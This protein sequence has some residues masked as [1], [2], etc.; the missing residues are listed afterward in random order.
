VYRRTDAGSWVQT[1]QLTPW[2][3][4][5]E[6]YDPGVAMKGGIAVVGPSRY[7]YERVGDQW[8]RKTL[9]SNGQPS[10]YLQGTDLEISGT[11]MLST[12]DSWNWSGV[13]WDRAADGQWSESA[14]LRGEFAW[15]GD[16]AISA[17]LDLSGN[18]A[19]IGNPYT[20]SPEEAPLVP[21]ARTFRYANGGW[22]PDGDLQNDADEG[23][24]AWHVAM[25][26][27]HAFVAGDAWRGAH[28]YLRN[29]PAQWS[30]IDR[31]DTVDSY[32]NEHE[33]LEHGER[34][35]LQRAFSRERDAYVIHV[36]KPDASGGYYHAAT[37]SR[38]DGGSLGEYFDISGRRI[39][40]GSIRGT[41]E[42]SFIFELPEQLPRPRNSYQDSFEAGNAGSQ[43]SP[44]AG[45]RFEIATVNGK[46]VYRQT[47]LAGEPASF[48]PML[49][50][51]GDQAI[52]AEITP[53][54]FDGHDR[55]V[56]LATRRS[57]TDNLYYVTLRTGTNR[58]ELKRKVDGVFATMAATSLNVAPDRTYRVR[59]ESVGP[60]HSVY[61]NDQRVLLAVDTSLAE[62]LPG[63]IM[64]KTAAD[65]DNVIVSPSPLAAIRR[66]D[67]T[68][69]PFEFLPGW[70]STGRGTWTN[71]ESQDFL[72]QTNN[73]VEARALTG[74]VAD[75]QIVTAAVRVSALNTGSSWAGVLA[76][77]VDDSNYVYA[78]LRS[79]GKLSLRQL[80][81]GRIDVIAEAAIPAVQLDRWYTLRLEMVAGATRVFLDDVE[82]L[83]VGNIGAPRGRVGVMTNRMAADFDDFLA[84]RP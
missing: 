16:N 57:D 78:I 67:F 60:K 80:V 63:V 72:R 4:I 43:W 73:G 18:G 10:A 6:W 69:S 81:N 31:L 54:R 41:S 47:S 20:E 17:S 34:F 42:G 46:Q 7:V 40:A 70:T 79:D 26:G 14:H 84:Y 59:L 39:I 38:S 37:L 2:E 49:G 58:L 77:Y 62:G 66:T 22:N 23:Q 1:S 36:F 24:F 19:I 82:R 65:F 21:L 74:S 5:T 44:I 15:S 3:A 30:R 76:R 64:Y 55:W 71:D 75:D 12:A 50:V 56:G 11:R 52:Q 68:A 32:D 33:E 83:A 9:E 53:R 28:V 51:L 13:A 61:V 35:V 27:N 45:S 25:R 29:A 48:T 8:V